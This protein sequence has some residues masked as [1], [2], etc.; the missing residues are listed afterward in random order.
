MWSRVV[1]GSAFGA[2]L[3][4]RLGIETARLATL[5]EIQGRPLALLDLDRLECTTT[6]VCIAPAGVAER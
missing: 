6:A 4:P 3:R 2:A 1:V 5:A